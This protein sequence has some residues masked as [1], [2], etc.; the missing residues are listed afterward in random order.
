[1]ET[2]KSLDEIR[3]SINLEKIEKIYVGADRGCRCGC[4]GKYYHSSDK[5]FQRALNKMGRL[6]LGEVEDVDINANNYIN[7]S[8]SNNK[9]ITLYYF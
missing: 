1:M 8:L 7:F 6:T 3:N 4:R 2:R 5:G 9:A